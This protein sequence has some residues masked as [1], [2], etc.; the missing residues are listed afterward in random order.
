M[1]IFTIAHTAAAATSH[2]STVEELSDG[3]V[4]ITVGTESLVIGEGQ[5]EEDEG[6]WVWSTYADGELVS[7]DASEGIDPTLEALTD[8]ARTAGGRA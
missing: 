5:T 7:A 2:P 8:W 4:E 3:N 1:N 6:M